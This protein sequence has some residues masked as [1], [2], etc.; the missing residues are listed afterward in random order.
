MLSVSAK[1]CPLAVPQVACVCLKLIKQIKLYC[2]LSHHFCYFKC[3]ILFAVDLYDSCEQDRKSL[4]SDSL[5]HTF[6]PT[7]HEG[8]LNF[9]EV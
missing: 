5:I 1:I 2:M 3:D 4:N 6:D 8:D 7:T 9:L